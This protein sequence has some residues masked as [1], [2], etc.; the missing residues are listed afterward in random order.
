LGIKNPFIRRQIPSIGFRCGLYRGR[1]PFPL[2]CPGSKPSGPVKWRI[3]QEQHHRLAAPLS[4]LSQSTCSVRHGPSRT[5]NLT[6]WLPSGSHSRCPNS[7]LCLVSPDR[8]CPR[9]W[10]FPW[11]SSC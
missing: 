4:L 9:P 5:P 6:R 2:G 11:P 1:Y 10:I 3:V 8:T 7:D